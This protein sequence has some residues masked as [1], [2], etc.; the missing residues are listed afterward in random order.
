MSGRVVAITGASSGV[1]RATARAFARR[2]CKVALMARG[3]EAL[4]AAAK[5][6]EALGGAAFV[7]PLDVADEAQVAAAADEIERE[8]GPIDVWINDAMVT[9]L[10]PVEQLRPD[11]I[12]RVTEVNY[13]GAVHGTMNALRLMRPR[14]HGMIL[15][16][17]SALAY[18]AI[19][20][21]AAYCASKFAL[22]G[23]TDSLRVE[24]M[25]EGSKIV[26]TSVHLPAVNTPQFNVCRSRLGR[27]PMP[28]PPIYQ[29]EF[30]ADG[31]VWA[32]ER[33]EREVYLGI[34]ALQAIWGNKLAPS[35]ADR[36]LAEQ[37]YEGQQTDRLPYDP[38]RPDN[39]FTPLPGDPGAHGP[40]DDFD[41][42]RDHEPGLARH[43]K[44]LLASAL[45]AG[46]LTAWGVSKLVRSRY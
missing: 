36:V 18:R 24:L 19:P 8:V 26:V 3:R 43:R 13:L 38:E 5:E 1:G 41:S 46:L 45:G 34:G 42:I 10:G 37:G 14:D 28:V 12:R 44:L 21:Q 7:R 4:D 20:L 29:P 35:V 32:S 17:G 16:V 11:E 23:F 27:H 40:F 25:H 6:V 22:R 30:V 33:N 39:L 2:G 15:Q 31:I 9:V